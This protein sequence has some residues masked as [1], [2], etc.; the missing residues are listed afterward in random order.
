MPD[1]RW[2]RARGTSGTG[3]S[4]V[5]SL[6]ASTGA[7][8]PGSVLS[9]LAVLTVSLPPVQVGSMCEDPG[10]RLPRNG[11][12]SEPDSDA[13]AVLVHRPANKN[14][15]AGGAMTTTALEMPERTDFY[16]LLDLLDP[17]DRAMVDAV[18]EFMTVEVA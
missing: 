1:A 12:A 16:N 3:P 7:L 17:E 9:V 4:I 13:F 5:D 8:E 6:P 14:P 11:E 18:R 15:P 2:E 10:V